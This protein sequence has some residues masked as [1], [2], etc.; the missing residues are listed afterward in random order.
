MKNNT[1]LII[2]GVLIL[3]VGAYFLLRGKG[4]RTQQAATPI[5]TR[6]TLEVETISPE[7]QKKLD[8]KERQQA[9]IAAGVTLATI[10]I[11]EILDR[12]KA[13]KLQTKQTL[14]AKA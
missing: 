6:E 7:E 9:L 4:E 11:G 12:K 13:K 1:V 10:G 2:G 8:K 14:S 3:G 5:T